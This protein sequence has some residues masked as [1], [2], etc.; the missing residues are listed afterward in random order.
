LEIFARVK[1]IR[2][3]M[4]AIIA[5]T[6]LVTAT[7]ERR[8][9]A[10]AKDDSLRR[11]RKAAEL[12]S[13]A[14][15][16][17]TFSLPDDI[18]KHNLNQFLTPAEQFYLRYSKLPLRLDGLLEGLSIDDF[19][20]FNKPELARAR[21]AELPRV[22]REYIDCLALPLCKYLP[23]ALRP[24]YRD[25]FEAGPRFTVTYHPVVTPRYLASSHPN[26]EPVYA[27]LTADNSFGR[28]DYIN[29]ATMT[30]D[31][32]VVRIQ[33]RKTAS[34]GYL[35]LATGRSVRVRQ[36]RE[37]FS[38][39]PSLR[40]LVMDGGVWF[41]DSVV[42]IDEGRACVADLNGSSFSI[43]RTKGVREH[44]S[45]SYPSGSDGLSGRSERYALRG[46]APE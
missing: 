9:D 15:D 43:E 37:L 34:G 36:E 7:S 22:I 1:K 40:S 4:F 23:A 39:L 14:R 10:A 13:D 33:Y 11:P 45:M 17:L 41:S 32:K 2:E 18:L 3:T 44:Y 16:L 24:R 30:L 8:C 29:I 38:W 28:D 27:T 42:P 25:I 6:S 5:F 12:D 31:S 19:V 46:E 21:D 26:F 35:D 20:D